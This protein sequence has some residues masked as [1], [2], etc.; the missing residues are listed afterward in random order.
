MVADLLRD[1]LGSI[2]SVLD[3][4]AHENGRN[5]HEQGQEADYHQLDSH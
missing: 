4:I 1:I 5:R 2:G 3:N